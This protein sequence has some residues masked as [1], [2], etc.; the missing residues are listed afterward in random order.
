MAYSAKLGK[1]KQKYLGL[2]PFTGV[3]A[4][5]VNGSINVNAIR[6]MDEG[7]ELYI[8]GV[9]LLDLLQDVDLL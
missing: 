6:E 3:L 5:I 8:N 7:K 2:L 4:P 9:F 1:S